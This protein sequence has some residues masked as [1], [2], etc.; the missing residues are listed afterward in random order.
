MEYLSNIRS[1]ELQSLK[2]LYEPKD[3]Q[4]G[5]V[6]KVSD[7]APSLR[8]HVSELL[9]RRKGFQDR[10][11]AVHS[12]ALEEVEQEREMEFEVESV[13]EVQPPIHFKALKIAKLHPH[14]EEFATTGKLLRG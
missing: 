2:Q 6:I 3:H 9:K 8:A 10:G 7:F 1:K 12:S 4:R 5:A 11:V 13:R 14:I